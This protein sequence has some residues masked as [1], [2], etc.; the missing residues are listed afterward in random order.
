[1][2]NRPVMF[3]LISVRIIGEHNFRFVIPLPIYSL[4]TLL[5][6]IEDAAILWG[7]FGRRT[8]GHLDNTPKRSNISIDDLRRPSPNILKAVANILQHTLNDIVFHWGRMD[9]V[10]VDVLSGNE[11]VRVLCSLR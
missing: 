5:D 4:F 1:M 11:K 7:F 10:D 6:I 9:F 3:L 2:S 8:K